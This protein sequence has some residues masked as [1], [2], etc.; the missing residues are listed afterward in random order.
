MSN[1]KNQISKSR[2]YSL[3]RGKQ[4]SKSEEESRVKNEINS[5]SNLKGS[6][7]KVQPVESDRVKIDSS[8]TKL[9]KSANSLKDREPQTMEELLAKEGIELRGLRRGD[10][11]EGTVSEIG[12]KSVY[13]DIGAKTEGLVV[14]REYSMA[15]SY[16]KTL[17]PGDKVD[18]YVLTPEN[19]SGQII[20]SLRHASA[21][22]IWQQIEEWMTAGEILNLKVKEVNRGGAIVAVIDELTGFVPSSQMSTETSEKLDDLVGKEL[23]TKIIDAHRDEG[24]IILSQKAVSEAGD[25]I[26]KREVLQG[27]KEGQVY[28]GKVTRI[29]PFGLFVRLELG[30]ESVGQDKVPM[31]PSNVE[32]QKKQG[33]QKEKEG[34]EYAPEGLV[35]ISELSWEKVENPEDIAKVGDEVKVAVLQVDPKVGKLSFS[36]K[37]LVDDPWKEIEKKYIKDKQ[38][39]GEV[40]DVMPFGVFVKLEPGIS[41]LIH[42]TK[43]LGQTY[44][45]GD[46]VDCYV[47][48]IDAKGRRLSLD[49]VLKAKPV[50]YK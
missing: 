36:I 20:L 7:D 38:V 29:V 33:N 5:K 27:L 42:I 50:G 6:S 28:Q 37:R 40:I 10:V 12:P 35:H 48:S 14:D 9:G 1:I 25:L 34:E 44:K 21:N 18:V 32:I 49:L 22:Y 24:K 41:G 47:E 2:G 8:K 17:Q 23:E 43:L 30:K 45:P 3:K 16:I 15:E 46:K 13:V 11:V 26:K 31:K 19:E 4:K 39:K